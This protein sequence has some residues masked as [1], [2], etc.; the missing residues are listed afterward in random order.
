MAPEVERT[1]RPPIC[2]RCHRFSLESSGFTSPG[3]GADRA[4]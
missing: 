3:S 4:R 1:N 2:Q